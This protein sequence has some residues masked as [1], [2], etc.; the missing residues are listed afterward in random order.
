MTEKGKGRLV[1]FEIL[2]GVF[3]LLEE[4]AKSIESSRIDDMFFEG[5]RENSGVDFITLKKYIS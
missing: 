1:E 5:L 4:D 3:V 2:A